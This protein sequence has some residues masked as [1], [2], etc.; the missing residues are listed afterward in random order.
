MVR[1]GANYGWPLVTHGLDLDG[2][3]I[4]D[5]RSAPGMEDPIMV[6]TP[7]VSPSGIAFYTGDAFPGWRGSLFVAALNAPGL[8]RL[9][10]EGDRVAGEERLL[11]DR[12]RLRHVVQGPDGRLYLLTDEAEGRVLRL[13]PA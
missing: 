3:A 8:V 2:S 12:A 6:W 1:A 5:L 13:D 7:V 10:T 11:W 4:S 9:P